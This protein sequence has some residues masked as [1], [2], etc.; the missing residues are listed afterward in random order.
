MSTTSFRRRE[1]CS[2][3]FIYN[4]FQLYPKKKK[5]NLKSKSTNMKYLYT[6]FGL[7]KKGAVV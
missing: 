3:K 4:A 7:G 5:T 6:S 2:K 1:N